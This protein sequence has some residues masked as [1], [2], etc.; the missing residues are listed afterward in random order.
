MG[1][2]ALAAFLVNNAGSKR[3]QPNDNNT[4]YLQRQSRENF[5]LLGEEDRNSMLSDSKS[6]SPTVAPACLLKKFGNVE[7]RQIV[8]HGWFPDQDSNLGPPN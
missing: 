5:G 6:W 4:C 2:C 3:Q 8:T 1:L 7:I